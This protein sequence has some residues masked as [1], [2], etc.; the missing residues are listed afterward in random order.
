MKNE[1]GI[2]VCCANCEAVTDKGRG[3]G[4]ME[5][6]NKSVFGGKFCRFKPSAKA[7]EVRIKELQARLDYYEADSGGATVAELLADYKA[8]KTER[9]KL[10]A[11]VVEIAECD[12]GNKLEDIQVLAVQAKARAL[13]ESETDK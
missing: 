5:M 13:L 9:D 8:V 2:E 12:F 4:N 10:K 7:Y 6:P 11:F 1:L 3:C